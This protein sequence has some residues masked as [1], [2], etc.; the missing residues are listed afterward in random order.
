MLQC[1]IWC[2]FHNFSRNELVIWKNCHLSFRVETTNSWYYTLER[3]ADKD[4][5]SFLHRECSSTISIQGTIKS[6]DLLYDSFFSVFISRSR[7]FATL[8]SLSFFSYWYSI[9]FF[10]FLSLE[11][12]KRGDEFFIFVD[13]V[14]THRFFLFCFF[15]MLFIQSHHHLVIILVQSLSFPVTDGYEVRRPRSSSHH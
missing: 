10:L 13:W 5:H 15:C 6:R 3:D 1:L 2:I 4:W 14:S 12:H 11:N 9:V 7:L 8:F